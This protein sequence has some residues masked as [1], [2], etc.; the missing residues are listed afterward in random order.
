MSEE[1]APSYLELSKTA[2]KKNISFFRDLIGPDVIFCSVI[3]GNAYGH[4]I[5]HFVPRI[6]RYSPFCRLQ[7]RRGRRSP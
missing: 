4:G 5:D 2:F 7:C 6:V 3:K 1:L